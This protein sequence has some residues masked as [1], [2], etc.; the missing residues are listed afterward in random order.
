MR[1]NESTNQRNGVQLVASQAS[2]STME[3]VLTW[4][5]RVEFVY[6]SIRLTRIIHKKGSF[7]NQVIVLY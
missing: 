4:G 6:S 3:F 2:S 1:I 5:G 7:P